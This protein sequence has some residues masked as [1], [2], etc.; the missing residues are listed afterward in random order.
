MYIYIY[1]VYIFTHINAYISIRNSANTY[2]KKMWI[3]EKMSR[4]KNKCLL[5]SATLPWLSS[6]LGPIKL[7]VRTRIKKNCLYTKRNVFKI[8]LN[9]T[10]IR[11]Y[12]PFSDWFGTENGLRP[13]AVLNQSVHGKY[14]MISVWFNNI[15]KRF[16]CV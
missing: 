4:Y 2:I 16:L 12:L 13:F 5:I 8:L 7:C 9:Q 1:I 15:S 3:H 11:L 14:N 6:S 10:E